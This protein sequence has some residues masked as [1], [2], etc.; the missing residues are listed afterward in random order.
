MIAGCG[1]VSAA[2]AGRVASAEVTLMRPDWASSWQ[3]RA[4]TVL[5]AGVPVSVARSSLPSASCRNW[6]A[7]NFGKG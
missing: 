2:A 3:T 4:P 7:W 6:P 1:L 5:R